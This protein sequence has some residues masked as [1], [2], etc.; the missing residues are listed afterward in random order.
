VTALGEILLERTADEWEEFFQSR[1]V[2]AARVRTLA[3]AMRDPHLDTR[4]V[5][6]RHTG[7]KNIPGEY[8]VP[9]AAFQF[10][11]GGPRIDTPPPTLGEHSDE[12]LQSLGYSA[13]DI[14]RM[15]SDKVI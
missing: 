2:P 4:R 7:S 9:V 6:H 10:A 15:R 8:T 5:R 3:E 1:H 13:V 11:D 14:Q 12:I